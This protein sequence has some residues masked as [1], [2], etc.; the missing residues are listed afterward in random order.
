MS[1]NYADVVAAYSNAPSG[2]TVVIPSGDVVWS[3]ALTVTKPI[4]FQGAGTNAGAMTK[5]TRSG[6]ASGS[7]LFYISGITGT[8]E[9][10]KM[11]LKREAA[12]NKQYLIYIDSR[13]RLWMY[14][15]DMVFQNGFG[16]GGSGRTYGLVYNCTFIN[17]Y[18]GFLLT[19]SQTTD[20]A[21]AEPMPIGTTNTFVI[22]DCSILYNSETDG[23]SLQNFLY[24]QG[25]ARY[26]FR[27]NV[28]DSTNSTC[29]VNEI[30]A[31]GYY[32]SWGRGTQCYEIYNNTIR[33]NS[34]YPADLI[35]RGGTHLIYSNAVTYAGSVCRFIQS[36]NEEYY[37]GNYGYFNPTDQHANCHFWDNTQNG[38]AQ[39]NWSR[40]S[41]VVSGGT[42]VYDRCA[43]NTSLTARAW[44]SGSNYVQMSYQVC[45]SY[46]Q[47]N[48]NLYR[49]LA[50][51]T[52]ATNTEPGVGSSW[53]NV[54]AS[55]AWHIYS[56]KPQ[57]GDPIYDQFGGA[58]QPGIGYKPLS[59]PHP[60][61]GVSSTGRPAAPSGL[62]RMID[63][64]P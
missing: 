48:G 8:V 25:A 57:P 60:F 23:L 3:N 33:R 50:N 7:S 15:S 41:V 58:S 19:Q 2:G 1:A 22:E 45:P 54:W 52:S 59:Y 18:M 10:S 27:H 4:I 35:L 29:I 11:W 56:R 51:H 31:H 12:T 42:G 5:I 37:N 21:W 49:C 30:D 28:W 36:W 61:R 9:F 38:V 44:C 6:D 13:S 34:K 47:N 55:D 39:S 24:G 64:L 43:W 40:G 26:V 16:V 14:M 17:L 20:A 62:R 32:H 53:T 63:F 46:V